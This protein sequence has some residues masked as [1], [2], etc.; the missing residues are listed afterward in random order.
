MGTA[1][2]RNMNSVIIDNFEGTYLS[3]KHLVQNG[4][5]HIAYVGSF[6]DSKISFQY[7]RQGYIQALKD[8]GITDTY[9]GD[10][11]HNNREQIL[12]TT[13][14]LLQEYPQVTAMVTC[15]D[16][17]ALTA[18]HEIIQSGRKIPSDISIIG[19]DNN[20]NTEISIPPL[21]TVN[22]DKVGMGRLAVQLLINRAENP[23][24]SYVT[25]RV[26]TRLVERGSVRNL[27]R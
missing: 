21:T 5:K 8:A 17:V 19:F 16:E 13:A 25:M 2:Y 11:A 6:P 23:D 3:V 27:C 4:H 1:L 10:C 18:M 7:R 9:F 12:K 14:R 22:V 24:Q 15:N 20:A 26:H